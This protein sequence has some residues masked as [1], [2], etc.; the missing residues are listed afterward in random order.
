MRMS[1]FVLHGQ[2]YMHCNYLSILSENSKRHIQYKKLGCEV[3]VHPQEI[4]SPFVQIVD[5]FK[6]SLSLSWGETMAR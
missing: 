5:D 6:L 4:L 2:K 3:F 1:H